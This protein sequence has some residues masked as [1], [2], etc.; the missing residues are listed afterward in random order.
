MGNTDERFKIMSELLNGIR[1][2]KLYAWELGFKKLIDEQRV[3]EMETIKRNAMLDGLQQFIWFFAPYIVRRVS[4]QGGGN[5]LQSFTGVAM[6]V[7]TKISVSYQMSILTFTC[8]VLLTSHERLTAEKAF[9]SLVLFKTLQRPLVKMP[10]DIYSLMQMSVSLSRLDAYLAADELVNY[11][12]H[13]SVLNFVFS[14]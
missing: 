12:T 13:G 11:V 3:K 2:V 4:I 5:I 1:V 10:S 9:V 8:Y 6:C 7:V 14:L